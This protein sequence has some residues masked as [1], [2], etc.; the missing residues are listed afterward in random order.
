VADIQ[1]VLGDHQDAVVGEAWLRE[2]AGASRRDVALVAGM[3]IAAER[4]AAATTRDGWR[5]VWN[6]ADRKRLRAWLG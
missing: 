4:A 5:K 1:S 2:A 6:A 3:L